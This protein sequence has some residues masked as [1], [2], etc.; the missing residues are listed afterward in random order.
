MAINA[1]RR[2]SRLLSGFARNRDHI[3]RREAGAAFGTYHPRRG[4]GA[5]WTM[6]QREGRPTFVGQP[7][8]SPLEHRNKYRVEIGAFSREPILDARAVTLALGSFEDPV[9]N[10]LAQARAQDVTGDAS[11]ALEFIEAPMPEESIA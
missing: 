2:T 9:G 4:P 10:Q 7:C 5:A 6:D 11:T 1:T 3:A 8:I